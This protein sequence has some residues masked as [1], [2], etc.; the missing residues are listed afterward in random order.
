LLG[1]FVDYVP[2]APGSNRESLPISRPHGTTPADFLE[3]R[4]WIASRFTERNCKTG[5]L[6]NI[7]SD[8]RDS[9]P[10]NTDRGLDA[11]IPD[12]RSPPVKRV[13][14]SSYREDSCRGRKGKKKCSEI[15]AQLSSDSPLRLAGDSLTGRRSGTTSFKAGGL[16]A[17]HSLLIEADDRLLGKGGLKACVDHRICL[18]VLVCFARA[19][20]HRNS[21]GPFGIVKR[22]L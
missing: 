12:T 17:D 11:S 9:V 19:S 7:N 10:A 15:V 18:R 4:F 5:E 14:G 1:C 8:L 22:I 6:H 3:A 13:R 21:Q 20:C 2:S 16:L